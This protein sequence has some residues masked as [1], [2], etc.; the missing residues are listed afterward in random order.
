[1]TYDL[2]IGDRAYS[3]WS[4]RTWLLFDVFDLPCT[5]RITRFYTDA[6]QTALADYAPA[7]T[8]PVLRLPSGVVVADTLAIAEELASRHPDAGLWPNA[9]DQRATARMLTAEMHA[10]FTALRTDCPMNLRKAY[11]GFPASEAVLADVDRLATLWAHA[12]TVSGAEG[13]W[14]FGDHSI[15][16]AFFA[17]VAARIAGYGLP[18]PA[19]AARYVAAHLEHPSFR[20]WRA[21]GMVDGSDQ[22][23]YAMDHATRAWPGP[24]PLKAAPSDHGPSVNTACPY[25]G[26]PVTHFLKMDGQTYGFCNAFCCDKTVADPAA[27]P[28]FTA[29]LDAH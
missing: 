4:L 15:A 26:K 1:M 5:V 20:R 16:D 22:P 2:L 12:R 25:S 17:P 10:S 8:V 18:V 21:M 3:S 11:D 7:R 13:P 9:P 28:A 27:W 14:L 24:V 6:F 19:D 23:K 29:L